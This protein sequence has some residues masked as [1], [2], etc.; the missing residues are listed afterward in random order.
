MKA[1]RQNRAISISATMLDGSGGHVIWI[2]IGG[3]EADGLAGKYIP[4]SA[5]KLETW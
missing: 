4:L 3:H 5:R 2:P 1:K